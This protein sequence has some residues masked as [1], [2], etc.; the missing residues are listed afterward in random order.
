MN[1]TCM[2]ARR[3]RETGTPFETSTQNIHPGAEPFTATTS[4]GVIEVVGS[5]FEELSQHQLSP[6]TGISRLPHVGKL[7]THKDGRRK[8]VAMRRK[9][10]FLTAE[11]DEILTWYFAGQLLFALALS[12]L[13]LWLH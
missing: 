5:E 6:K 13:G 3:G 4:M 9:A 12:L 10:T 7:R 11:T 1:V 8:E 2:G